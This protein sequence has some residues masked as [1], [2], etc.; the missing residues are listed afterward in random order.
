MPEG[1]LG[2]GQAAETAVQ[3]VVASGRREQVWRLRQGRGSP[4]GILGRQCRRGGRARLGEAGN[5][6][7]KGRR[8]GLAP[9][10]GQEGQ[11]TGQGHLPALQEKSRAAGE[12]GRGCRWWGLEDLGLGP[13]GQGRAV[14]GPESA[15]QASR[16]KQAL[17]LASPE[18]NLLRCIGGLDQ[19]KGR[20][21][22]FLSESLSPYSVP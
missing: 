8:L 19:E 7:C 20:V 15:A 21:Y 22:L 10:P 6:A 14:G 2:R 9:A 12:A 17:T 1:L 3:R 16:Q 13:W 5:R 11:C 18:K 4:A